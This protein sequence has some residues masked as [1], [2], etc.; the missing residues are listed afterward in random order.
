MPP[1]SKLRS[2]YEFDRRNNQDMEGRYFKSFQYFEPDIQSGLVI[3]QAERRPGPDFRVRVG[4][5]VIGVEVTRLL[6]PLGNPAIEATQQKILDEVCA[7]AERLN[8]PPAFVSLFFNL[9]RPLRTGDHRIARI[10][11]AVVQI[12]ANN[13]PADGDQTKLE[14]QP[15]QPSEVDLILANRYRCERA[16]WSAGP[17]FRAIERNTFAIV[18]EAIT[19][20]TERLRSYLDVCDECWL[21]L[22]ADSFVAS[23]NLEFDEAVQAHASEQL[24]ASA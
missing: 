11:D 22:V 24:P 12:V 7:R 6:T 16:R 19:K 9:R 15:G 5:N 18:Q 10:A 2:L 1:V 4:D 3:G 20:K 17:E 14:Q 23:G 13:M 8:L 21:L